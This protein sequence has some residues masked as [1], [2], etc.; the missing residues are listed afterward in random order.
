MTACTSACRY[1]PTPLQRFSCRTVASWKCTVGNI[2]SSV[3]CNIGTQI[4]A[5]S[6]VGPVF[7][8]ATAVATMPGAGGCAVI[9]RFMGAGE[10]ENAQSVGSLCIGGAI[11]F[12][13][14]FML[15][16][17]FGTA[18]I[19]RYLGVGLP[20][21][22]SSVFSGLA[23]TFSNRIL[24]AYGVLLDEF[25]VKQLSHLADEDSKYFEELL[26]QKA[27]DILSSSQNEKELSDLR[28]KNAQLETAI[29]NQVNNLREADDSLKRF[30]QEDVKALT[31]EL[32]ETETLL[33]KLADSRQSQMYAIRDI[34]E[35][36]E[37]VEN[38]APDVLVTLIQTFVERIYITDENDERHCHIFIKGCSKED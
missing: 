5:I 35:I 11:V 10:K 22:I 25:V 18:P 15:A 8:L 34:E 2:P 30:I 16:M 12:G 32:S 14:V 31:D 24:R 36:K 1:P 38:A 29:A 27:S 9:A 33:Q 13:F 28:K 7:S 4:A 17:Q 26:N 20:N 3:R 6:V 19:L 21:G 37:Y 23:S